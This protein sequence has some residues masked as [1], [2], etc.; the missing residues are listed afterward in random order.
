MHSMYC[1]FAKQ[2]AV[3][4]PACLLYGRSCSVCASYAPS[5]IVWYDASDLAFKW[6]ILSFQQARC[7]CARVHLHQ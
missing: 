3:G 2:A 6:S 7:S 5:M 4:H 1:A